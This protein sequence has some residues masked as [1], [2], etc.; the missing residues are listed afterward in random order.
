MSVIG[1]V[2]S[3]TGRHGPALLVLSL[4]LGAGFEWLATVAYG[5]LPVS[6]FLLT[7]GSFLTASLAAPEKGLGWRRLLVTL[8]WVGLALQL[9]FRLTSDSLG[10]PDSEIMDDR[11]FGRAGAGAVGLCVA[12]REGPDATAVPAGSNGS[13]GRA[14]F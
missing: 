11:C 3:A 14:L 4:V 7:L 8:A 10:Y 1:Q 13:L 6:A 9:R 5:I 2:L 12:G